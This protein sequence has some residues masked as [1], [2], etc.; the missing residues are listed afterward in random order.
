MTCAPRRRG[1]SLDFTQLLQLAKVSN[2]HGRN[3]SFGY[4]GMT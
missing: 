3:N 2:F 4:L 1:T